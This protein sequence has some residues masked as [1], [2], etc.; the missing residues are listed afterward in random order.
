M[1]QKCF[2]L[3]LNCTELKTNGQQKRTRLLTACNPG[4]CNGGRAELQGYST[5]QLCY[6]E[7]QHM[8]LGA[9]SSYGPNSP[10]LLTAQPLLTASLCKDL[11]KQ[12]K[13][14]LAGS[15]TEMPEQPQPSAPP[16]S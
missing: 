7:H 3:D 6:R 11:W 5:F 15:E 2:M 1:V 10:G 12:P 13:R 16:E 9:C 14:H 4:A 8:G